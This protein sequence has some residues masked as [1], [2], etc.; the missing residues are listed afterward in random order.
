MQALDRTH[1][2]V[3]QNFRIEFPVDRTALRPLKDIQAIAKIEPIEAMVEGESPVQIVGRGQGGM[4][5]A[6]IRLNLIPHPRAVVARR[7]LPKGHRLALQDLELRP[8]PEA[9]LSSDFV[10][11]AAELVGQEARTTLRA[12]RPLNRAEIGPAT[13][14]RKGDLVEVRVLGGGVTVTTNAKAQNDGAEF[15]LIEVETIDPRKRLLARVVQSGMVEVV[16][17]VPRVEP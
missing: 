1:P 16:T 7:M 10:L 14:V 13:L 6:V 15:D 2:E 5:E 11:D 17:R 4:T 3:P 8:I 12:G 9:E